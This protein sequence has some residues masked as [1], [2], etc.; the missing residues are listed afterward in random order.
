MHF[1]VI[2]KI[3]D[4]KISKLTLIYLVVFTIIIIVFFIQKFVTYHFPNNNKI[5]IIHSSNY[6]IASPE[7]PKEL[8]FAGE[9]VPLENFDV[10]ESLDRELLVNTFFH[11]QTI[12]S[13]KRAYRFF[14]IVEPI[15]K[16]YQIPDDF[17]YLLVIESNF[18]NSISPA[19][20]TGYWQ[21]MKGTAQKYGLEMTEEVDERYHLVKSTEAACK[22]LKD[23]F[24][25]YKSW[26]LAAAAYNAGT[27]NIDR[28]IS[29]QKTKNY[30]DL[31][32][33]EETSRYV[34]RILA[35]KIIMTNPKKYGFYI[36][37]NIKY[38]PVP[39]E[40]IQVDSS[41]SDLSSFALDLGINYKLLRIFN[42][43]LRKYQLT[44]KE[45]KVY[46]IEIPKKEYRNINKLMQLLNLE[47]KDSLYI[48]AD[49]IKQ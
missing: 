25:Y 16:K 18:T 28:V 42:P 46:N 8:N 23:L 38:F 45:R 12:L 43:W 9:R 33:N 39:T 15:L 3:K 14:P 26:T 6:Y 19:G 34:F 11:S 7:I 22:H 24:S 20:A 48:N 47:V 32:L 5:E 4:F 1:Y 37:D 35:V 10:Y 30:Y 29:L 36:P 2:K 44:N 13:L 40:I 17:K 49:S 31:H 27:G 21:F 41:I